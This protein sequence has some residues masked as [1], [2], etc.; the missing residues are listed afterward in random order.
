MQQNKIINPF[1]QIFLNLKNKNNIMFSCYLELFEF[2]NK[3]NIKKIIS[4]IFENFYNY[5]YKEP[6][7]DKLKQKYES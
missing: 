4:A 1:I 2:I 6:I 3:Q 5:P 7:W